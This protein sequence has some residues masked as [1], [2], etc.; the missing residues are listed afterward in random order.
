MKNHFIIIGTPKSGSS[1]LYEYLNEHPR[2]KLSNTKEHNFFMDIGYD[3]K[4]SSFKKFKRKLK[5]NVGILIPYIRLKIKKRYQTVSKVKN[6]FYSGDGSIN[7]FYSIEVPLRVKTF[8]PNSKLILLLRNPIDRLYSNYWMNRN[9]NIKN[10]NFK[11]FDIYMKNESY[12]DDINNYVKS[13]KHWLKYFS[14]GEILIIDSSE[15]FNDPKKTLIKVEDFL[16]IPHHEYV[17]DYFITPY[18][19]KPND[20]PKMDLATR[21][22]LINYFK[23]QVKELETLSKRTYDWKDFN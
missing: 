21:Q 6:G 13:L 9:Q 11:S 17:K 8:A 7:Y 20:Y 18:Q 22:F 15:F 3:W 2:I 23:P 12:K 19:S 10:W 5:F 14:L 16:G 4:S 1:T